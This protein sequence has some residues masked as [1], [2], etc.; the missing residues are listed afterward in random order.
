MSGVSCFTQTRAAP[1]VAGM[2]LALVGAGD[3]A[4]PPPAPETVFQNAKRDLDERPQEAMHLARHAAPLLQGRADLLKQLWTQAARLEEQRLLALGETEVQELA[5][6][7]ETNLSDLP[8]AERVRRRWLKER[9][10]KLTADD[11]AGRLQVARLWLRW[12]GEPDAAVQ[13]TRDLLQ[14]VPATAHLLR[15]DDLE[16]LGP[17]RRV[18]R[19]ILYQRCLE[20]RLYDVSFPLLIEIEFV[21][22]Q[23]PRLQTVRPLER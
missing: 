11:G 20:Q 10:Q 22:G 5:G 23:D 21:K 17:P 7:Y 6:V 14:L 19:Q 8:A 1:L 16:L 4:D 3:G 18:T 15:L 2:L 12:L 9:L 13:Q